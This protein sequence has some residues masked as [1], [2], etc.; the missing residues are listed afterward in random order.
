MLDLNVD[1]VYSSTESIYDETDD[2]KTTT[3]S[4]LG[5]DSGAAAAV[6]NASSSSVT[7]DEA[8]PVVTTGRF[9]LADEESNSSLGTDHHQTTLRFSILN[10]AKNGGDSSSNIIQ[11]VD[12]QDDDDCHDQELETRQ[13]FP[14][15]GRDDSLSFKAKAQH[16]LNLSVPE[17]VRAVDI[18]IQNKVPQPVSQPQ[19]QPQQTPVKKSR[20]GPRSRSSQYR[21]VT[22][23]RRTGRWESHIWWVSFYSFHS[24][25]IYI[26]IH[27][28]ITLHIFWRYI[29]ILK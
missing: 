14:L 13:L 21:G 17:V 5:D 12:D 2:P 15:G 23:Y 29:R 25:C 9:V 20:R 1:A 6:S 7:A 16:W 28:S 24:L 10:T 19:S 27:N 26:Y 18:G 4:F 3:H 22:F 11:I 8:P